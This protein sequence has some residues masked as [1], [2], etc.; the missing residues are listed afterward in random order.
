MIFARLIVSRSDSSGELQAVPSLVNA[1]S[2]HLSEVDWTEIEADLVERGAV[3]GAIKVQNVVLPFGRHVVP[4]FVFIGEKAWRP[5]MLLIAIVQGDEGQFY[6]ARVDFDVV[7]N[8]PARRT[9]C[10]PDIAG[11][12]SIRM[13]VPLR[14][15][16]DRCGCA[17]SRGSD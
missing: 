11:W 13:A 3:R 2:I 9:S 17:S 1:E 6:W 16:S 15:S 14:V 8:R 7:F 4:Q 10:T 12:L 5:T